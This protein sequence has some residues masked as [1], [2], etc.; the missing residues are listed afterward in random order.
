MARAL[1]TCGIAGQSFNLVGVPCLSGNEYLDAL[2]RISGTRIRRLT[3]PTWWLFSRSAAK[4]GV[5]TLTRNPARRLPSYRYIDGL[6]CRASYSA[7]LAKKRLTWAPAADAATLIER[8]IVAPGSEL[9]AGH[10]TTDR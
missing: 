1:H 8:G 5:Q 7:D 10:G 4:W 3:L 9:N 2:E 6:S